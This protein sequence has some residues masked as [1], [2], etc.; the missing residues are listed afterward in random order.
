MTGRRSL[1]VV[2]LGLGLAALLALASVE[3]RRALALRSATEIERHVLVPAPQAARVL[4]LGYNE[5]A[6]DLTWV[7]TLIYYGGGIIHNTGNPDT[8]ALVRLVNTLDPHFRTPYVWG[9]YATTMRSGFA[10]QEEYQASVE[11]LRRGLQV[12]PDD[13]EL[14]WILG[15]RLY[16]ELR[17]GSE[18]EQRQRKE[19]GAMYIE[20]AMHAPGSP[21]D[22]PILAATLR[23][24]LGQKEQ[25]LRDLREMILKVEDAT[26]RE[27]LVAKYAALASETASHE[28][29]DAAAE[30]NQEWRAQ[31]PYA[32]ATLYILLGRPPSPRLDLEALR[33]AI[34]FGAPVASK[35]EP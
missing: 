2:G 27:L 7:R 11:V 31:L 25:A 9:A 22:L 33:R 14:A 29:A 24:R 21:P 13:W 32:P 35:N 28:L 30:F 15:I 3:H 34:E 6:A 12:F 26:A 18:D 4:S 23:T 10:T 17:T 20:R 8:E 19:E 16:T 1:P 5:L